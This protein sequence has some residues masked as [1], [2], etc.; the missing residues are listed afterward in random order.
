VLDGGEGDNLLAAGA[1]ED[2]LK[3]GGGSDV[4]VAG[5]GNDKIAAGSGNDFI[6]AG[7]GSDTID[8]GSGSDFIAGGKGSDTVTSG[9]GR[10]VIAYNRGDGQ[11]V[12]LA[13]SGGSSADVL[14]LGGGIRYADLT[15]NRRGTDLILGMGAADQI[16]SKN[17]YAGQDGKGIAT[18][19]IVTV[20]GD[21]NASSTSKLVGNKVVAFDFTAITQQY[22]AA[23]KANAS[24]GTWAL[25]PALNAA[26]IG[27]SNTSA[28][29]GDLAFD[30][31]TSYPASQGYGTDMSVE[32]VRSEVKEQLGTNWQAI[33][34]PPVA[35]ALVDPWVA[36]QAGTDLVAGG[37]PGA[38]N[39]VTPT[40][41][42]MTD[43]L[44]LAALAAG[45]DIQQP[46]WAAK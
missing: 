39:P 14:S 18:L 42:P 43:S 32:A 22:D 37:A 19:Q 34:V 36:L 20:G 28:L 9:A 12:L 6:D 7:S 21:Y 26:F 2:T 1:G 46:T 16:T 38:S 27:A 24:L 35:P 10:D 23:R 4:M 29:G 15:L 41:S 33:D 40:D 5:A 31:A 3:S 45:S 8:A 25:Q 13:G 11:D 30:Y 17:W 44:V